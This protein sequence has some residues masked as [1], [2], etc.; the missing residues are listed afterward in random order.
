MLTEPT[1][2]RPPSAADALGVPPEVPSPV[3]LQDRLR[4]DVTAA[5]RSGDA[6]RRDTLRMAVNAIYNAEKRD[7]RTYADDEVAAILVKEVKTRR[8]SVDAFEKGGRPDL[9]AKEQAEISI[10]AEFLPQALTEAEISV[11]VGQAIA[12]TG[13]A[14]PRD[15]GKVMGWL[16]AADPG[17]SRRQ[18]PERS[19]GERARPCRPFG[20]RHVGA[21][22]PGGLTCSRIGAPRPF[23]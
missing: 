1:T 11:L 19:R 10:L 17:A 13:A 7:R 8:E 21:R 14:S 16:C 6:L 22:G 23:D 15:M 20:A 12:E 3:T 18:G 2:P 9:A 5:M 4:A